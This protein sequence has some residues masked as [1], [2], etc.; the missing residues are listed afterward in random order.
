MRAIDAACGLMLVVMAA[1]SA[2]AAEQLPARKPGLWEVKMTVANRGGQAVQQ[3]VDAATDQM[4]QSLAGPF[5][6]AACPRHEVQRSGDQ[7]II[8]STCTVAGKTAI[9]HSVIS[10]SFDSAYS[11]T[12]TARSDA[13]SGKTMNMTLEGKWLGACMAGQKGGDVIMPGGIKVNIRDLKKLG[14]RPP[15]VPLPN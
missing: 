6:L 3:C 12:V 15:G 9:T 13:L 4:L 7:T 8:D 11:M 2:G 5:D 1:T 10:G 14:L